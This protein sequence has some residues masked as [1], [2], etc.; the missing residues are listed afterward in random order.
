MED[1]FTQDRSAMILMLRSSQSNREER[2]FYRNDSPGMQYL[3]VFSLV[4][5][6]S[7]RDRLVQRLCRKIWQWPHFQSSPT[8]QSCEWDVLDGWLPGEQ[9][10]VKDLHKGQLYF[11]FL[12]LSVHT[13]T[14]TRTPLT[15]SSVCLCFSIV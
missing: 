5:Q 10:Q 2:H 4:L 9:N 13:H 8:D 15:Y 11:L 14:H 6:T 7:N 1:Y 3:I 12:S